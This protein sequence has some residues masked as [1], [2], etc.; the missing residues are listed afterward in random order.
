M[1]TPGRPDG[2]DPIERFAGDYAFL[3]NFHRSDVVLDGVTYPTLEHAFQAAK[4][5]DPDQR[6]AI[7]QAPSPGVAK[8]LG[9]KVDLTDDWDERRLSVM[10][11]LLVDKFTRHPELGAALLAT[12]E[13]ELVEGNHWGDRFWG[14]CDGVGHNRLGQLLTAIRTQLAASGG[15]HGSE[16]SGEVI[17]GYDVRLYVHVDLARR[18]IVRAVIDSATLA[19]PTAV[20]DEGERAR[21]AIA[22]CEHGDAP[23]P[24]WE[25]A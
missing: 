6:Q 11:A 24:A 19:D 22:A 5:T 13:R 12:G 9:R 21:A 10:H 23:W 14:V 8:R 17:V 3:S 18:Q 20:D 25:I 16:A 4:T 1:N 2:G 7:R 15:G